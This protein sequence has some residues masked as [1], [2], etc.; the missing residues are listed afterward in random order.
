MIGFV[1][2]SIGWR[3]CEIQILRCD[4]L[5]KRAVDQHED[6]L[7]VPAT[8]GAIVDREGRL[9]ALSRETRSL[10]AH[11]RR[12]DEPA[13]A[14][15]LLA[16]V[17]GKPRG[18]LQRALESNK[19]FV[20]LERF[21]EPEVADR[22]DALNLE[23]ENEGAFG[24]DSEPRR[25][26][27]LEALAAHVVG[28]ATID[29]EG[30][31]GIELEYDEALK[32]DPQV[33]LLMRDGHADGTRQLISEPRKIPSDVVLSIDAVLQHI[34]ERELDRA[35]R[36]HRPKGAS[37]VMLDPTS[38]EVLA[39]ANRPTVDANRFGNAPTTAQRNRAV[40]DRF[41]PGSTFKTVTMAAAFEQGRVLLYYCL[42]L[43][44]AYRVGSGSGKTVPMS[45][46]AAVVHETYGPACGDT[47]RTHSDHIV[48]CFGGG[49]GIRKPV[50]EI[51]ELRINT[52]PSMATR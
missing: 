13:R 42:C 2:L 45:L 17:L 29:G 27:P 5:R 49:A 24:F 3:L 16:P 41:E 4:D 9:L 15:E 25:V 14:A 46:Y 21:L 34:V 18:E 12:V 22:V 36:I 8:R 28:F 50:K 32:G 1:A 6:R 26:Y 7:V 44:F 31:E 39:L 40:T 11:P 37:V 38:G 35:M 48:S 33:Y 52:I 10:Y 51:S 20:Y 47:V 30:V 23:E 43:V 19:S